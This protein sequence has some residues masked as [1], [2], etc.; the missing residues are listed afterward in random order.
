MQATLAD[1]RTAIVADLGGDA[2]LSQLQQ[3]LVDRYL[4]LDTVA[5][6]L[7][8]HLV[9]EG[10]LTAKGRTRNALRPAMATVPGAL[11]MA[12]S[13]SYARRGEPWK[14]YHG[15]FG[16][17]S[18]VLVWQANTRT[19]NRTVRQAFI[20]DAYATDA[21]TAAAEHGAQ[22]RSDLESFL[23]REAVA[24]AT[25][26][27]RRELRP[28]ADRSY[29]AFTDP[30]GG[31]GTDAM[32][33]AI[34]HAEARDGAS[35]VVLDTVR[36]VRPPFSPASTVEDFAT[37]LRTYGI[38]QVIGDR[39]AGEWPREQFRSHGIA[40]GLSDRPKS[41]LYQALLPVL[42]SGRIQLLDDAQLLTQLAA[43]ERRTG[44]GGRDTIDHPPH[45]RDDLINA[46][47]GAAHL[48]A[49]LAAYEPLRLLNAP[50]PSSELT[51]E[52]MR[53]DD[54]DLRE[55]SMRAVTDQFEIKDHFW[56]SD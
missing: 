30:A 7:G 16:R 18:D 47:A 5:T 28:V 6:W 39:Y 24:A 35:M 2:G 12:I 9:A 36:E 49:R 56:P 21:P 32:T 43:L 45:Q 55:R 1:Q 17:R 53:A 42:N 26:A 4:E 41:D 46:A 3:D 27:A 15:H 11:L 19:M 8:G 38:T 37:L 13:T 54:R 20:D 31:S 25:V 10:P 14:A 29:V 52:E 23:S 44:H 51:A 33:L 22:F 40:Y 34:A 48:V 50:R